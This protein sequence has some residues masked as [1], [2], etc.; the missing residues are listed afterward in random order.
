MGDESSSRLMPGTEA[1]DF[2]AK[3]VDGS[4]LT[5][6]DHR[7]GPVWLAFFRYAMCPLCNFRI[8]QLLQLWPGKF[9]SRG[10]TMIGVFQSP[11]RKLEGLVARHNPPFV[12]ISDPEL[13][14]YTKYSVEAK[15]AGA[16]GKATRAA[17]R[18]AA[19]A[20]IPLIKPWDGP[21]HRVPADF[22]LDGNGTI[23]EV[24]Y[25]ENIADHIP[26]EQVEAFLDELGR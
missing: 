23:R 13:Q 1:P 4:A 12:V 3:T 10:I 26:F 15:W 22:L 24:F 17:L 11:A 18:G 21:P 14:L 2:T 20:G 25:G 19:G 7:G 6:S 16:F 8:H 9:A 5:L